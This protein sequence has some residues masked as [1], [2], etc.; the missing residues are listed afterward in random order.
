MFFGR[1]LS[2]ASGANYAPAVQRGLARQALATNAPGASSNVRQR[3]GDPGT[4]AKPGGL[5]R[6]MEP[7]NMERLLMI[8][9]LRGLLR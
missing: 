5:P 7:F 6:G 1:S 4:Q 9:A 8:A 2:G 3:A